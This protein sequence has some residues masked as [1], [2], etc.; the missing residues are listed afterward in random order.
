MPISKDHAGL[1][2]LILLELRHIG[3]LLKYQH[4]LRPIALTPE[5]P[6]CLRIKLMTRSQS[7]RWGER[8]SK[9]SLWY[10]ANSYLCL[11]DPGFQDL[12]NQFRYN[13]LNTGFSKCPLNCFRCDV[14]KGSLN[15]LIGGKSVFYRMFIYGFMHLIG[16]KLLSVSNS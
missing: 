2:P 6:G 8:A 4:H 3:M 11:N 9:Y 14:V 5:D 15:I 1:F 10:L 7:H 13:V 16:T 12:H